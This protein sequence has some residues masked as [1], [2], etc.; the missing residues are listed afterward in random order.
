MR[1]FLDISYLGTAFHGWQVQDNANSVQAEVNNALST[2][3]RTPIE[4]LGSGRT[5][6]GVHALCQVA[7]FDLE[8]TL[9]TKSIVFKLNS[10]L[11]KTIA[12]NSCRQVKEDAHARFDADF[13]SY[14]Y[15]FHSSK[16]PFKE[17]KSYLFSKPLDF[18]AINK[19]CELIGGWKNFEAFSKVQTEVNNFNCTIQEI[20][21]E[22]NNEGSFFYVSANR[23]LRG[24]VRAMVGTLLEVGQL[25]ISV[26]QLKEILE[27]KDRRQAGRAVPPEGL[28]LSKVSY[29]DHIYIK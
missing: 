27:S 3:L 21:W 2:I 10:L 23:F 16:N 9:D 20:G 12:I 25:K 26:A 28:Y 18:E 22:R 15:H 19:S 8:S 13:R 6:T 24:M 17:G 29:P 1:F 5:D 7:H 14:K 4:C 11:P